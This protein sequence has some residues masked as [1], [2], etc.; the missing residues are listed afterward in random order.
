MPAPKPEKAKATETLRFTLPSGDLDVPAICLTNR[1]VLRL[2]ACT[3]ASRLLANTFALSQVEALKGRLANYYLDEEG[4]S[5]TYEAAFD[6]LVKS[7]GEIA[8]IELQPY[9]SPGTEAHYMQRTLSLHTQVMEATSRL[10]IKVTKFKSNLMNRARELGACKGLFSPFYTVAVESEMTE[11]GIPP[12]KA[13]EIKSMVNSQFADMMGGAEL[14]LQSLI[15]AATLLIAMLKDTAKLS[16]AKYELCSDQVS[17]SLAQNAVDYRG[18][19][20]EPMNS[21][22]HPLAGL[23]GLAGVQIAD[24]GDDTPDPIE[25]DPE[26]EEEDQAPVVYTSRKAKTGV[27][28]EIHADD[29]VDVTVQGDLTIEA[30]EVRVVEPSPAAEDGWGHA[31]QDVGMPDTLRELNGVINHDKHEQAMDAVVPHPSEEIVDPAPTEV[32]VGDGN[33]T[34]FEVPTTDLKGTPFSKATVVVEKRE[35]EEVPVVAKPKKTTPKAIVAPVDETPEVV[36]VSPTVK[37]VVGV[38]NHV[39]GEASGEELNK[40]FGLGD[41]DEDEPVQEK[42]ATKPSIVDED[43]EDVPLRYESRKAD[44]KATPKDEEDDDNPLVAEKPKTTPVEEKPADKKVE[45]TPAVVEP[46]SEKTQV[47]AP[48]VRLFAKAPAKG[49]TIKRLPAGLLDDDD[50]LPSATTADLDEVL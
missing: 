28:V 6:K 42:K 26:P 11:L 25:P 12:M 5:V 7:A 19:G 37:P 46:K 27:K 29:S 14:D 47:V 18:T 20:I 30:P 43:E 50:A 32:A 4:A 9:I 8:E 13:A 35:A 34:T 17:A 24:D 22:S 31:H 39:L 1:K 10:I 44:P 40:A 21:N 38:A 41:G 45:P 48:P 23:R 36:Q 33:V 2:E 49:Q 3:S 16:K 15:D